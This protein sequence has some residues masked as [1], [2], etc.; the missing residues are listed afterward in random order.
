[1]QTVC[2][3]WKKGKCRF[4]DKCRN[5]HESK[6]ICKFWNKGACKFGDKCSNLH[7]ETKRDIGNFHFSACRPRCELAANKHLCGK[8][9]NIT[10]P[11]CEHSTYICQKCFF[12]KESHIRYICLDHACLSKQS[13]KKDDGHVFIIIRTTG[14]FA[15]HEFILKHPQDCSH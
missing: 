15:T 11:R 2:I 5:L 7:D 12:T 6:Q 14:G 10:Y 1:M 13:K 3:F 4:A 9:I 8:C